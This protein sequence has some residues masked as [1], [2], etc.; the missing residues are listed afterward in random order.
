MLPWRPA[1]TLNRI[2]TPTTHALIFV[3]LVF[4]NFI[5]AALQTRGKN[6]RFF[7]KR[8]PAVS[9][10]GAAVDWTFCGCWTCNGVP[11]LLGDWS[12]MEIVVVIGFAVGLWILYGSSLIGGFT[13]SFLLR[14]KSSKNA[15]WQDIPW[16]ATRFLKGFCFNFSCWAFFS[17]FFKR[18]KSSKNSLA[19]GPPV[20][21]RYSLKPYF[22]RTHSVQTAF[23]ITGFSESGAPPCRL[24][25]L[26]LIERAI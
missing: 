13:S 6:A 21:T 11:I 2:F 17:T 1:R 22:K 5:S 10:T 14:K 3:L 7:G 23:K 4:V 15:G 8:G 25:A 12:L 9:L 19:P 18:K 26:P 16:L 20:A 24:R